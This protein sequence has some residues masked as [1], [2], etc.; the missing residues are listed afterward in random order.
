MALTDSIDI[1]CERLAPDFW[2]E[3]V[4]ALTNAAFLVAALAAVLMAPETSRRDPV[5]LGFAV[6]TGIIG[7][8]SFAF[9]TLATRGALLLDVLPITLFIHLYFFVALREMIGFRALGAGVV[10]ALFFAGG[11]GVDRIGG[12]ALNGS[13]GYLPALAAL[14][15]IGVAA[16]LAGTEAARREDAARTLFATACVF[17]LS[18]TFRSVDHAA[19]AAFPPGTHFLWHMLNATVLFLLVRLLFA[20]RQH[21]P[22]PS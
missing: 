17:A 20:V 14:L 5:A 15:A 9:H 8:G 18:L 21:R 13:V 19:C 6:L 10:T 11:L 22:R 2:A 7:L 3:P 1:Y 12:G 4:N 16:R